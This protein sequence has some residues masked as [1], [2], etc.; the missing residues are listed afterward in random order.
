MNIRQVVLSLGAV[1]ITALPL[2]VYA[3]G[4][5]PCGDGGRD[6]CQFC[7][8]AALLNNIA[9]WLVAILSV[10]VAIIFVFAGF[11][12][13]TSQGNTTAKENAKSMITNAFIGYVIVLAAWLAIDTAMKMLL[14]RDD[15]G[16][17]N[18]IQC[19]EQPEA[20]ILVHPTPGESRGMANT[21]AMGSLSAEDIAAIAALGAP[22]DMIAAAGVNAGLDE[23]QIRNLQALNRVESG[24]CTIM[25]SGAGAIG[26]MQIMP[27]T[28][29]LY[30]SSLRGLSDAQVRDKLLNDN[31]YNIQLGAQIYADLYSKY[32]GNEEL[33][34]AAY[35][36]GEGANKQSANCSEKLRWQCEWDGSDCLDGVG[37]DCSPNTGY[38]E[39]RDYVV[40]VAD[41]SESL[42]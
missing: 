9:A 3:Q 37:S 20:R 36:G 34:Y 31:A 13:V 26:C 32:D 41:V 16:T 15:F 19:V 42:K 40:K 5:V 33:V 21:A 10:V 7:H 28:A 18:T 2:F 27:G 39:T 23:E 6:A 12:L 17:W 1:V 25:V 29:R 14:S 8:F 4:L 35:N 30:D 24:G 22:D 38:K 11:K